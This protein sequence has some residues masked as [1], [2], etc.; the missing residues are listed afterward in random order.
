MYA[1]CSQQGLRYTRFPIHEQ[2]QLEMSSLSKPLSSC[3]H[4]FDQ[5]EYN[6][7]TG[8]PLEAAEMLLVQPNLINLHLSGQFS[9]GHFN[10]NR[11]ITSHQN[12][13]HSVQCHVMFL[14]KL[15]DL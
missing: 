4:V 3:F 14:L 15:N 1:R 9:P 12:L 10:F 2:A 13:D 7:Q 5:K 8:L 11:H 6:P